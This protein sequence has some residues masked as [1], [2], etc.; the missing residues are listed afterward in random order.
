MR[1]FLLGVLLL[2]ALAFPEPVKVDKEVICD[3]ATEMLSYFSSR[4]GELPL[5]L[6]DTA[7]S[8]VVVLA[9]PETKTWTILQF[10]ADIACYIESGKGFKFKLPGDP[11]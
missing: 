5:W 9:N 7:G 10:N 11:I 2:P 1:K 8:N 3:K 4:F 6:G